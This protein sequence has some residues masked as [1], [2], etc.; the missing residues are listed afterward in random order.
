MCSYKDWCDVSCWGWEGSP[1]RQWTRACRL[2][3]SSVTCHLGV[4]R[5]QL[6]LQWLPTSLGIK[7]RFLRGPHRTL[8]DAATSY[9]PLYPHLLPLISSLTL[10]Y[11]HWPPSSSLNIWNTFPTLGPLHTQALCLDWSPTRHL[12]DCLPHFTKSLLTF[13]PINGPDFGHPI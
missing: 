5:S 12:P 3:P 7:A 1:F 2:P 13:H 10:L 8:S 9:L 4:L 6:C 11:L